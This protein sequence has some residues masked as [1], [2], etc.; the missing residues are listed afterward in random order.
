MFSV[1][2]LSAMS[3]ESMLGIWFWYLFIS[4]FLNIIVVIWVTIGGIFDLRYL[5]HVLKTEII[6]DTDNGRVTESYTMDAEK[7]TPK[8][9][10]A[11]T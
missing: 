8:K 4:F 10:K 2:T 11:K 7:A 1:P 3:Y 6:D 9:R 5:F